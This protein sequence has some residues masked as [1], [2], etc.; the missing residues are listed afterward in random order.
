MRIGNIKIYGVIYKITNKINGKIYIGQTTEGFDRRYRKDFCKLHDGY[1]KNAI[2]KY[3]VDNFDFCKILDVAFSKTELDIK[4]RHYIKLYNSNNKIYG[5]NLTEGGQNA[6]SYQNK[7]EEEMKIIKNKIS[8]SNKISQNRPKTKALHSKN[9]KQYW[10]NLTEEEKIELGRKIGK[11]VVC[12]ITGEVFETVIE[13]SKYYNIDNSSICTCCNMRKDKKTCGK[14]S[15]GTKLVWL[16]YEDYIKLSKDEIEM[17]I[18]ERTRKRRT[19]VPVICLT[20]IKVFDSIKEA[21][22]YYNCNK[23]VL[24]AHCKKRKNKKGYIIH[25]CG[26]LPDGTKLVWMYLEDFLEKCEYILL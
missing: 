16:Y 3:G 15:D 25:S 8:K 13:A 2:N 11:K 20:T 19:N 26:K 6:S 12:L 23:S 9:S 18:L 1:L 22:E 17:L 14:L 21:S 10:A 4:E 7:T 5:Y 24:S